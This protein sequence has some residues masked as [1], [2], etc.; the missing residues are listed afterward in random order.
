MSEQ[1]AKMNNT[2]TASNRDML[3]FEKE[4]YMRL[5]RCDG[6]AER[7]KISKNG[8]LLVL[9]K[10]GDLKSYI[11]HEAEIDRSQTAGW[12]LSLPKM[13]PIFHKSK[14]LVDDMALRNILI[15][16]DLSLK[17]IDFGQCQPFP[18]DVDINA[19]SDNGLTARADIFH[20]DYAIYSIVTWR[21]YEC[22]LFMCG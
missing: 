13:V 4:V 22:D 10:R 3:E 19:V 9:Y 6:I 11:E 1:I 20:L 5:G 2:S 16:D 7:V 14:V 15:A 21:R 8:I 12:I 18:L 17:M